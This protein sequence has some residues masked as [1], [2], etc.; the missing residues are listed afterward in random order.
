MEKL[1]SAA[2][3]LPFWICNI[4]T[5]ALAI[6]LPSFLQVTFLVSFLFAVDGIAT[7]CPFVETSKWVS[8]ADGQIKRFIGTSTPLW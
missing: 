5:D 6:V 8:I 3:T 1:P 7:V 2:I 4:V